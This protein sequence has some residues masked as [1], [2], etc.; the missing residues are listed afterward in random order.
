MRHLSKFGLSLGAVYLALCALAVISVN[1]SIHTNAGDSGESAILLFLIGLPWTLGASFFPETLG[2]FVL[3]VSF[4]A[5][6]IVFYG[7]GHLM[8]FIFWFVFFKRKVA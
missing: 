5:N 7:V 1:H 4:L 8:G 6:A 3:P 2:F